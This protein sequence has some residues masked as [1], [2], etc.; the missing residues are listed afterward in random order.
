M[1]AFGSLDISELSL[2]A[3]IEP[4]GRRPSE[5]GFFWGFREVKSLDAE[6]VYRAKCLLIANDLQFIGDRLRL[7]TIEL[8]SDGDTGMRILEVHKPEDSTI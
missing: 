8:V 3:L 2:N 6:R 4:V 7:M 1:I 5:F